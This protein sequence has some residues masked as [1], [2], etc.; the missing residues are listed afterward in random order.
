MKTLFI[1]KF[2]VLVFITSSAVCG[3]TWKS[4]VTTVTLSDGTLTVSGNG[5]ME[6][7]DGMNGHHSPWYDSS[8]SIISVV[9]KN[10]V[11]HIGG[12]VFGGLNV[13][14][15]TIPNSVETIGEDAFIYSGLTSI[16]IPNSVTTIGIGAFQGCANLTSV[17]IGNSVTSIW[18]REFYGCTSLTSINVATNNKNYSSEDGVLFNKDKTTLIIYPKGKNGAYTIPESVR[19]IGNHAFY[20]RT[21]LTS[22]TIPNSV[23]TIGERAF[24]NFSSTPSNLV[25]II[26][27]NP[28]PPNII[29]HE[30]FDDLPGVASS[31]VCLY[32]PTNSIAAYR[33]ADVWNKFK[34][35]KELAPAPA[36]E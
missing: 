23:T 25:S 27:L 31:D 21:N 14:S 1:T 13:K 6:D 8:E 7:Y 17:T 16:T 36:G 3:Q 2:V 28:V 24:A 15:I 30:T 32:V 22:V 10:G 35:I 5:A 18:E 20:R 12:S 33:S 11:T 34:C 4:G 26:S 9:I 19:K 29:G